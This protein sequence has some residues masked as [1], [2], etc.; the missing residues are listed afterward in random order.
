AGTEVQPHQSGRLQEQL[1]P[2]PQ[3]PV[4]RGEGEEALVVV[5][6]TLQRRLPPRVA[7]REP[8]IMP[9]ESRI[10]EAAPVPSQD[11]VVRRE[12]PVVA[13]QLDGDEA[14]ER[15]VDCGA[16]GFARGD[17]GVE[18]GKGGA[19]WADRDSM[20][21][22]Q[23]GQPAPPPPP[24]PPMPISTVNSPTAMLFGGGRGMMAPGSMTMSPTRA[25]GFA[26]VSTH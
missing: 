8:A 7:V 2:E 6:D 10:Q 16:A 20:R 14:R 26:A 3:Q 18:H 21:G 4:A 15:E 23:V 24:P 19:V 9:L 1:S 12:T 5:A 22:V 11:T 13:L 25:G 17:V